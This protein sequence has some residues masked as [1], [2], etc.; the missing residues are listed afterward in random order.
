[1][2]SFFKS[3]SPRRVLSSRTRQALR[4]DYR[5]LFARLRHHRRRWPAVSDRLHLGCGQRLVPGWL[6]ADLRKSDFDVDLSC[7]W[8]PWDD[9]VFSVVVCQ[10]VIE[11]LDLFHE[12]LPLLHELLRVCQPGAEIWF[13]CPDMQK[14]CNAYAEDHG[15]GLLADRMVRWQTF[16]LH[17]APTQHIINVLF[18]QSGEHKNLYDLDILDW[19]VR[20]VGFESCTRS[21]ESELLSRFPDFPVRGDDVHS[22]YIR[23][24]VPPSETA[25]RAAAI[26]SS[27]ADS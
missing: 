21:N 26:V 27:C 20:S 14:V 19:A 1:M 16:T 12:L 5:R 22:L 2:R 23:V 10:Q 7:G 25:G 15:K 3:L 13:A 4:I 8:L 9:R 11:H 17:G 18:H 6:N 24:H